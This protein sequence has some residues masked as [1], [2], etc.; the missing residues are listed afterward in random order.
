MH[1]TGS[2]RDVNRLFGSIKIVTDIP[3]PGG[4]QGQVREVAIAGKSS[5][6]LLAVCR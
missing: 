6:L 4:S 1:W 3:I 5:S 2:F